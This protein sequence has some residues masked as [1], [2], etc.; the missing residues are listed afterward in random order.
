MKPIRI[1]L[2][3]VLFTCMASPLTAQQTSTDT[4][5][6]QRARE[7]SAAALPQY[8]E[9]LTVAQDGSGD[10]KTIQE[11]VNAVRDLSQVQVFIHIKAGVYHEK[12]VIPSWKTKVSLIGESAASTTITNS[13]YSGKDYPG[14][15]D[16]FGRSKYSTYTSYTVLVQGNDFTATGLTIVNASGRVGQAVALHV[17]ADRVVIDHCRLLGN[18]DTL[19]TATETSRQYYKDCFIEGTTDF[20][21]GEATAVFE[22]CTIRNLTN[23]YITAA[24]T[25]PRQKFGYVFLNCSLVA[26]TGAR[27][28]FMGRPWRPYAKTVFLSTD[29]GNHIVPEGWNNWNNAENE[30]T[31]F[32]AEYN[33]KGPGAGSGNR[34]RWSKQLTAREAKAYTPETIFAGKDGW[35]PATRL[36]PKSGE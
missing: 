21:F 22:H 11:A 32:Y 15:K 29:M 34:V 1:V 13:D 8:P 30:K 18:Q 25:T 27:R 3:L 10:Y 7:K 36:P 4:T 2:L 35:M 26:D 5:W 17:E 28:C 14:G 16:P 33:S 24:S 20:I 23:S 31:V 19:Y 9:H 12:L 6:R